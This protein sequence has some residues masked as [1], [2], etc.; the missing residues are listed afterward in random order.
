MP[1]PTTPLLRL[2]PAFLLL[3]AS[4]APA[5]PVTAERVATLPAAAQKAWNEYLARSTTL[6]A[7]NATALAAELSSQKLSSPLPAPDGGDFKQPGKP[8]PAFYASEDSGRLADVIISY[9]TPS[10][11]WSKH[12]GYAKGPRLPGMLWSSQYAPGA[13]PHYL[14]TFD[15]RS[16]TEQID[17]LA[18][19][20]L[21]TGRKD[22][23]EAV[24]R[25]VDF[26]LAAQFPSGGWPQV[27]PLEG[28]YH[29]NITFN[30]DATTRVLALLKSIADG[31]PAYAMIEPDQR[32][33]VVAALDNGVRCLLATQI[34]VNGA[35]TVWC[36]QHDAI[37]LQAE[38]ARKME[39]AS[40]S[41]LESAHILEFLMTFERP[42]A[43]IVAA[44]EAG[45]SWL[46]AAK[47]T[48][49]AKRKVNGKTVYQI[50]PASTEIY[51]ARFY[52]METGRPI[53]PG[54]DHIVY[55]SYE[56]MIAKNT[57]GYDY[58]STQPG[59]LL[60]NGQKKWRK[61]LAQTDKS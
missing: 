19:V 1:H 8:D 55:D 53:F 20:A 45:L 41:G 38:A 60:K 51:W 15:N 6:A 54:R 5:E 24:R 9:Q 44:I 27:Y 10:G 3:L 46:D 34:V 47:V 25:G 4:R 56:A 22:C 48:N 23:A 49:V 13:K 39:P 11:G 42:S 7:K 28:G 29:D 30:D 43:E 58:F 40:L 14:A 35:K 12:T 52:S 31:D 17:F 32:A 2:L 33:R 16:T 57:A 37:T 59:S 21:A 36:A 26:V 50:D 18:R 61:L